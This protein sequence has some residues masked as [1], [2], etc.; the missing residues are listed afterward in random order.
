GSHPCSPRFPGCPVHPSISPRDG[1][2]MDGAGTPLRRRP[3]GGGCVCGDEL[4][5]SPHGMVGRTRHDP[6][7][8]A[9][10]EVSIARRVPLPQPD[11]CGEASLPPPIST[12]L[13]IC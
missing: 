12:A 3:V 5:H 6:V 4:R 2:W 7:T 9:F 8:D 11:A 13:V 10:P 1:G